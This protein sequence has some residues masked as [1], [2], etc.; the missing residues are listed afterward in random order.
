M[1][2]IGIV[3]TTFA[4]YDMAK[5]AIDEIKKNVAGV[6]IVRSTVPGVKDLP[7]EAKKLIEEQKCDLVMAFGM[8]GK[9][10]IDKTCAHEASLGI[11]MAQLM[12]NTHI[13][14][15]FVHED[16]AEN[17]KEL[18]EICKDRATKH[19]RNAIKLL[20]HPNELLKEAGMGKRQGRD[21]VGPLKI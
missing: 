19:A 6:S 4:R 9:E 2:K 1:A 11:I 7:V 10:E 3:D 21:D 5:D 14:E 15:V 12:T 13:V 16:E 8:P 20:F 18:I 17:E